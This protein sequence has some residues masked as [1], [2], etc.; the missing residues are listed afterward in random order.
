MQKWARL[1]AEIGPVETF[2]YAYMAARRKRP[3]PAKTL[4]A[5]HGSALALGREK[6]GESVVLIGKSMGGRIGCHV[7]LTEQLLGRACLGNVCLGYPLVSPSVGR[8]GVGRSEKG[9]LRDAVLLELRG[10]VCFVQGTRDSLCPLDLLEGVIAKRL[11]QS[12]LHVVPSG[13]HSLTPTKAHLKAAQTSEE[14]LDREAL[15][16]IANFCKSL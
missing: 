3:D 11:G 15:G 9:A 7:A 16:A 1:L 5:T 12:L 13:D 2:D 4:Q 10:P 8:S 14:A 6:H